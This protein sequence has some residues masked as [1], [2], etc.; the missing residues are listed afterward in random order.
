MDFLKDKKH[1]HFIGI[2]GSGMF[3]IVQILHD[4]GYFITG[5]DNNEGDNV[6]RL[7]Q[8]GIQVYLGHRPENIAGADLIVY[9]AAIQ[10]DNVE[11]TAAR[12]SGAAVIGRAEMLGY[13]T[14]HYQD[15]VCVCGTHGKTTTT[16]LLTQLLLE[17]GLDPSAVIGGKLPA[18]HGSGRSGKTELMVC[19]SCEFQD[20]FLHLDPD[21]AV[22]LN[23][24]A[25]HMEYFK[26]MEHVIASFHRFA[27]MSRKAVIYNKSDAN[28]CQAM[29][30]ITGKDA[31][32]FGLAA[33]CDYYPA[34]IRREGTGYSF[35]LMHRGEMLC[36]IRLAIP[37]RHNILNAV[38][39]CAAALYCGV[40][41]G[42]LEEL[43]PHFGGAQRRF[44]ILGKRDG[45]VI[46]DDY[47]HHPR[48]LE[49]TLR[50]AMDLGFRQVWA[51]FQP[52]T[53]S[54][55]ALF[56]EEF[57]RVLSIPDH[58]VLSEIMGGREK[59]TYGIHTKDLAEKI[60]GCV[61]FSTFK[62]ISDYVLAHAQPGD[63][64]ITLGCGDIY[65]CANRMM[66]WPEHGNF[67][68]K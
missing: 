14:R 9:S 53:F 27:E 13:L 28:T 8:M 60:P 37:G 4:R 3:P 33:D 68:E 32:S 11:L 22:I 56:L 48:E 38:A 67:D 29:A 47:A 18:I 45:V 1:L 44:Q 39:A 23:V 51:V 6:D 2:G 16:A 12:Q 19:E 46:A 31:I 62:E 52:F 36:R 65:K 63:L 50:T 66:G 43:V 41:P 34:E 64:V 10:E 17:A 5:T 7:R 35:D 15:C 58:A 21:V 26:T 20:T 42:Q 25:D 30:G 59:N 61:W 54:R 49:V 57:A 55:T 40:A 24:D